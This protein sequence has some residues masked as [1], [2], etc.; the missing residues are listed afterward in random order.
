MFLT[1]SSA[2]SARS[3]RLS[4]LATRI[5][6]R[7]AL[8]SVL[9]EVDSADIE[10]HVEI[11]IGEGKAFRST[12]IEIGVHLPAPQIARAVGQHLRKQI[13]SEDRNAARQVLKVKTGAH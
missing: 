11:R 12:A 10:D 1:C 5:I 9:E 3:R 6:S 2:S 7:I 13:E 4:S 8:G